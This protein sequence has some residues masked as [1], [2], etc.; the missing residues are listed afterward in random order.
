[1]ANTISKRKPTRARSGRTNKVINHIK[2]QYGLKT[3]SAAIDKLAEEYER[4]FLEPELRPEYVA[5]LKRIE[6][7]KTIKV[8]NVDAY[9]SSL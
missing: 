2:T 9:F 8:K 5:K 3:R 7:Q 6:R 1:M 4:E